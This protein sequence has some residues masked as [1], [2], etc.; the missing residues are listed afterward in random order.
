ME[1]VEPQYI[2]K[3]VLRRLFIP[4]FLGAILIFVVF[5]FALRLNL[6]LMEIELTMSIN[7]LA[8]SVLFVLFAVDM[9]SKYMHAKADKY[10]FYL[11]KVVFEGRKTK[12]MY[13]SN[14]QNISFKQDV[15]DK[16]F[17]TGT[18]TLVPDFKIKSV[19]HS[20]QIYFYIQKL[21]QSSRSYQQPKQ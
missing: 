18:I 4:Q 3:P 14:V 13:F 11:D 5:Y 2:L 9:I 1:G 16:M 19:P 21:I 20:N 8:I 10:L 15:L 6:G 17:N 12:E 7:I